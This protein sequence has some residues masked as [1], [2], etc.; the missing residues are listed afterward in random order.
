[1]LIGLNMRV[2]PPVAY[3]EAGLRPP[4]LCSELPARFGESVLCLLWI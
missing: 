3:G 4:A 2:R 1:M